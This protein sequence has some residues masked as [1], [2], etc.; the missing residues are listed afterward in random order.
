MICRDLNAAT[1]QEVFAGP[2]LD[3]SEE[4]EKFSAAF[5]DMTQGFLAFP[6]C[7]P[8]TAVWKG[9][10]G[11]LYIIGVLKRAAARSK[12]AMQ[13]S[14]CTNDCAHIMVC[15]SGSNLRCQ[16]GLLLRAPSSWVLGTATRTFLCCVS[17]HPGRSICTAVINRTDAMAQSGAEPRCLMDFWAQ[18]CLEEIDEADRA[19]LPQPGHTTDAAMADTVMDFLFASQDASTAS[20][21]WLTCVMA[22]R[23]DILAKVCI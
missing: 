9:K 13:V 19:G 22:D 1:S 11:R 12:L 10:Q 16:S 21:V 6:L 14:S 7:V 20:L 4:K 5:M 15:R 8:G 23:S 17:P 2:Y 18:R 3:N